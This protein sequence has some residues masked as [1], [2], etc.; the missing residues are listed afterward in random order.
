MKGK[1]KVRQTDSR[2]ALLTVTLCCFCAKDLGFHGTDKKGPLKGFMPGNNL[3]TFHVRVRKMTLIAVWKMH[4]HR[5]ENTKIQARDAKGRIQDR[6]QGGGQ[7]LET[8]GMQKLLEALIVLWPKTGIP[9]LP[10]TILSIYIYILKKKR[11]NQELNE[12]QSIT[13]PLVN[14]LT[15]SKYH[16]AGIQYCWTRAFDLGSGCN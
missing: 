6:K 1:Y 10:F 7:I 16:K 4:Q 3:I 11:R 8:S 14:L 2:I 9:A 13:L 5:T 12:N 15:A